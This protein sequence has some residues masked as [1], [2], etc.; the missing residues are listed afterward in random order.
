MNPVHGVPGAIRSIVNVASDSRNSTNTLI[1][2]RRTMKLI[3]AC[4]LPQLLA[5]V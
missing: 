5:A 4:S 3:M 1:M 2:A